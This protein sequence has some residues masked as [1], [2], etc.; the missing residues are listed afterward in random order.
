MGYVYANVLKARDAIMPFSF[1]GVAIC[2]CMV[3]FVN[4]CWTVG[5]FFGAGFEE[6][7][8]LRIY[9]SYQSTP[10][11]INNPA[12]PI[13]PPMFKWSTR[14]RSCRPRTPQEGMSSTSS[15]GFVTP[16]FSTPK[17]TIAASWEHTSI[18]RGMHPAA[19]T[20]NTNVPMG[21]RERSKALSWS[22]AYSS[23]NLS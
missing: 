6:M 2:M 19:N 9:F 14:L 15:I 21:S 16:S 11:W 17:S 3:L 18:V 20:T 5:L 10:T 1:I 13:P 22:S 8:V 23:A 12:A 7:F 4:L